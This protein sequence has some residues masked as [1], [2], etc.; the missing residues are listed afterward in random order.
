M[1]GSRSIAPEHD[2]QLNGE[3]VRSLVMR[4]SAWAGLY[5]FGRGFL[6]SPPDGYCLRPTRSSGDGHWNSNPL[7][8]QSTVATTGRRIS[9]SLRLAAALLGAGAAACGPIARIPARP[10]P[11]APPLPLAELVAGVFPGPSL[12]YLQG[13]MAPPEPSAEPAS[14]PALADA[15]RAALARSLAPVLYLHRDEPFPLARAVA[16]VHPERRVIAYHL[17]W[18]DDAYGAW[19]PGTVPTDEEIV[20]VGYDTTGAPTELWTYWHGVILHVPWA[21]RQAAID[22]QWGKHGSLPRGIREGD[23]PRWRSMRS[24]YAITYALPD[25]WLGNLTRKGPWCFCGSYRRY[26]EFTEPLLLADQLDAV[27]VAEDPRPSLRAVF[28]S[29]YSDKPWWPWKGKARHVVN[30]PQPDYRVPATVLA[31]GVDSVGRHR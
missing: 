18:E 2:G 12:A 30:L 23:L 20:W 26:L 17:L 10:V 15:G 27:V 8:V 1:P 11:S 29:P 16:V 31:G 22:V 21:G 14:V 25:F 9:R 3:F 6:M 4:W 24:F 5:V 13:V 28:G 7:T 19:I